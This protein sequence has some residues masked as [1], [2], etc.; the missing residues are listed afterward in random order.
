MDGH[1]RYCENVAIIKYKITQLIIT[2]S[3]YTLVDWAK[4]Y[5]D[6]IIK[7]ILENQEGR[8]TFGSLQMRC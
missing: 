5:T 8:Y 6:V 7:G 3:N 1:V 4:E 2:K